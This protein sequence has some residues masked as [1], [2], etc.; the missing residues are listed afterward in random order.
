MNFNSQCYIIQQCT[1]Y[2]LECCITL[3]TYSC[4]F[5]CT[6][7]HSAYTAKI[8]LLPK[9][10][11]PL[12]Q[13]LTVI[14]VQ[15]NIDYQNLIQPNPPHYTSEATFI[16]NIIIIYKIAD[17]LYFCGSFNQLLL[18]LVQRSV[19]SLSNYTCINIVKT[20]S[21]LSIDL[22]H[23]TYTSVYFCMAATILSG[24]NVLQ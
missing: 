10:A 5:A 7:Q 8:I 18:V 1:S 6:P 3:A 12:L 13:S 22:M 11:P 15:W 2:A 20:T 14:H 23:W 4:V 19:S 24:R 17:L 9:R 21:K 16:M